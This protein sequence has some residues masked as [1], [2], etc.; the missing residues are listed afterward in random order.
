MVSQRNQYYSFICIARSEEK[1]L[2]LLKFCQYAP[3]IASE[4]MENLNNVNIGEGSDSSKHI[5]NKKKII[6]QFEIK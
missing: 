2:L 3:S 5:L 4:L 6:L 1:V